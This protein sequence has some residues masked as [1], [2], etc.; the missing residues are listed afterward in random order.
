MPEQIECIIGAISTILVLIA[1]S[2][3]YCHLKNQ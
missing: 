3:I 2:E 1:I